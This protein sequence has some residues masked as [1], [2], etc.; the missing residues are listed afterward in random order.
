MLLCVPMNLTNVVTSCKGYQVV[1]APLWLPNIIYHNVLQTHQCCHKCQGFLFLKTESAITLSLIIHL[2]VGSMCFYTLAIVHK[3]VLD[4]G[5]LISLR[6][7]VYHSLG[8]V[9]RGECL[10]PMIVV[11]LIFWANSTWVS[12]PAVHFA[13]S[14]TIYKGYNFYMSSPIILVCSP[15]FW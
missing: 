5:D 9:P 12:I 10:E 3:A 13:F 2:S 6:D 15:C 14:P 1:F 7:P 8:C 11:P 4:L